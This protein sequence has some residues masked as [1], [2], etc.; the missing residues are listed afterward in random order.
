MKKTFLILAFF[1][2]TVCFG[3]NSELKIGFLSD[4]QQTPSLDSLINNSVDEIQKVIGFSKQ[5]LSKPTYR[6]Y[7]LAADKG[8]ESR[9]NELADSVDLVIVIGGLTTHELQNV[10]SLS[11]PTFCIGVVEPELQDIAYVNGTTNKE[12]FTYI[13]AVRSLFD[14]IELFKELEDFKEL[15]ILVNSLFADDLNKDLGQAFL[16]TLSQ[17]LGININV[18]AIDSYDEAITKIPEQTDAVYLTLLDGITFGNVAE[19]ADILKDKK[20]PSFSSRKW[21]VDQG[22]MACIS[23]E[24]GI[25][26]IIKRLA[27]MVDD[28][29]Q[30]FGLNEM[31]VE[32]AVKEELFINMETADAIGYA[33]PLKYLF[34]ANLVKNNTNQTIYSLDEIMAKSFDANLDIKIS[35]QNLELSALDI[36]SAQVGILPDLGLSVNGAQINP[37]RAFALFNSPEQ[38]IAAGLELSQVIYNEQTIAGIKIA[39]YAY[40]SQSFGTQN[41]ILN[42][43]FDT[44]A[45]YFNVLIA[46]TRLNIEKENLS[47]FETNRDLAYIRVDVGT[48]SNEEIYRWESEVARATQNV[49]DA[50][51]QYQ[52]AKLQLN[53]LLANELADNYDLE[54]VG[55]DSELYSYFSNSPIAE[56]VTTAKDFK[57]TMDFLVLESQNQNPNKLQLLENINAA[58]RLKKQ[59]QRL[60]YIP[61]FALQAQTNQ[62]LYRGGAGS[63]RIP[64][65][66]NDNTYQFGV[67]LSYPIFQGNNRRVELQ[68]SKVQLDQLANSQIQLDQNLELGVKTSLLNV[69][70][71]NTNIEFSKI[72]SDNAI[73]NFELVQTKYKQGQ[74]NITQV[75]DAQQNALQ[76]KLT[77]L[78]SIY[79]YIVSQ[80]QLEYTIGYFSKF[81]TEEQLNEF[82][83]RYI[84][85]ML[86]D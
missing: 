51:V 18:V 25:D 24:N 16:D 28:H 72:A 68:K 55:I 45:E 3:Q 30:G 21:Q 32:L 8:F 17:E 75:I 60:F 38:Q 1:S 6:V 14:E 53:F 2:F 73:L 86:N 39:K 11:K 12:N 81:S 63:E 33:P 66:T 48:A 40:L 42:V 34:I 23:D 85:F 78:N 27:I 49:V 77:Y 50:E 5:V 37:E 62:L 58:E 71:S 61:S 10:A 31:S 36:K 65:V 79:N 19:L 20:I 47:I 84:Q 52:S 29:L 67:G 44:Y 15:S 82:R 80:L 43:M 74:V 13:W 57:S 64:G 41:D 69:L 83:D 70:S 56:F 7:N 4:Y 35:Y 54:D 46:K 59:N 26:Q 76:A 22:I 9:Y